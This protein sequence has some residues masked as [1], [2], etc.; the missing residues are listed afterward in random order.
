MNAISIIKVTSQDIDE[1]RAFAIE[2]FYTAYAH[3]ND[4]DQM[5]EYVDQAFNSRQLLKEIDDINSDFLFAKN[6]DLV[7]G[8]IKLNY[9]EAQIVLKDIEAVELERIYVRQEYQGQGIGQLLV[10]HTLAIAKNRQA[11]FVWLGVW[12]KNLKAIR[13]YERIGFVAFD[14]Y[15]FILGD[16]EQ[17]D[18]LMRFN[19]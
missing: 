2:T 13:F 11:P 15:P 12:D 6:G 8:Y 4:A 5:K 19:V 16:E 18:V 14:S 9:A 10:E 1:L 3:N 17:T 7:V